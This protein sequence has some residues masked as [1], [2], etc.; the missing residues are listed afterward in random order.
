MNSVLDGI[1][2]A[3]RFFTDKIVG[4]F[5]AVVMLGATVLAIA[6][7]IRRYLFGVVWVWGQDAVTYFIIGSIFLFFAVTQARRSHL[8]VTAVI[9]WLKAKGYRKTVLVIRTINSV[10][11]LSFFTAFAA[12]GWPAVE[13]LYMM[14]RMTQSLVLPLWP[15]Q[16]ALLAGFALM[17]VISLFQ[18]Y[19]DIQALRG[20]TVFPWAETEE[21]LEI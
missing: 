2:R 8:A 7:I 3:L 17:A 4:Y 6:E 16:A 10:L 19:Q 12:W 1:Y 15:F 18:L 14:G 13:R 9:D 21:G 11:A 5:A 20:K